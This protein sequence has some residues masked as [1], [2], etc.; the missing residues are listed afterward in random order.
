MCAVMTKIF[1]KTLILH[2]KKIVILSV[3]M[4]NKTI[5]HS[6]RFASLETGKTNLQLGRSVS[7]LFSLNKLRISH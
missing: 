5:A 3:V 4:S 2:T 1:A 7:S 6:N